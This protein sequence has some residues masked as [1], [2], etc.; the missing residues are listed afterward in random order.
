M[1]YMDIDGLPDDPRSIYDA[2]GAGHSSTSIS[3]GLS[4]TKLHCAERCRVISGRGQVLQSASKLPKIDWAGA[5]HGGAEQQSVQSA[6]N[7]SFL[8]RGGGMSPDRSGHSI[9]VIGDG[10]ITGGMAWE[11][12]NHAAASPE[13]TDSG[14]AGPCSFCW[15]VGSNSI[16]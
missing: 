1:E 2:F 4:M 7:G 13:E 5:M 12:M 6:I 15:R 11:A 9:A 10:A 3:P 16:S 8:C 14:V